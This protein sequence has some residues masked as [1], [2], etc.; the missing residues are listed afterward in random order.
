MHR[1]YIH[2]YAH[3][4]KTYHMRLEGASGP[5]QPHKYKSDNQKAVAKKP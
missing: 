2:T 4:G 3:I 1:L 5:T